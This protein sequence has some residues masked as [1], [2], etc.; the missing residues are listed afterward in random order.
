MNERIDPALL[1][2]LTAEERFLVRCGFPRR[3]IQRNWEDYQAAPN[4]ARAAALAGLRALA[5]PE[6]LKRLLFDGGGVYIGGTGGTGKTLAL[7]ILG[8]E[9]V[10]V[11]RA[12]G[13]QVAPVFVMAADLAPWV[14]VRP[15][16]AAWAERERIFN[17]PLLL[18]DDVTKFPRTKAGGEEVLLDALL[19]YRYQNMLATFITGQPPYAELEE[20][21]LRQLRAGKA[22]APEGA[23]NVD[24]GTFELIRGFAGQGSRAF[25]LRGESR[26]GRKDAL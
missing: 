1:T 25:T 21:A 12:A 18:L 14:F 20:S 26:R 7:T 16:D 6:E 8:R 24:A 15:S 11:L 3:Y 10:H 22:A 5:T 9:A 13:V 4:S 2:R 23:E 17:T 19:R